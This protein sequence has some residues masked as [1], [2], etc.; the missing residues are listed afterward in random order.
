MLLL[1]TFKKELF[2]AE[3]G[4]SYEMTNTYTCI[5]EE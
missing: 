1:N 5:I 2:Q 4:K 3:N